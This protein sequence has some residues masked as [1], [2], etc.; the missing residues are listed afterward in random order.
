MD[1]FEL[2][3]IPRDRWLYHDR[4]M[5]KCWGGYCQTIPPFYQI[6]EKQVHQRPF[7]RKWTIQQSTHG[8]KWPGKNPNRSLYS[9]RQTLMTTTT[10]P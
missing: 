3:D 1:H 8:F 9:S 10:R 7:Y 2:R 4:S 6:R 5:A